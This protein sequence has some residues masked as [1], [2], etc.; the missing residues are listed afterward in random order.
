MRRILLVSLAVVVFASLLFAWG[1]PDPQAGLNFPDP[2]THVQ[3]V[4]RPFS[5]FGW[6][7]DEAA[8]IDYYEIWLIHDENAD[9]VISD[10]EFAAREVI[11][12][13]EDFNLANRTNQRLTTRY[14]VNNQVT[15][16]EKYFLFLYAVGIGGEVTA[17]TDLRGL[18][19]A[20]DATTPDT[21]LAYFTIEG[22]RP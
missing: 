16:A 22:V 15:G 18:G 8:A 10:T 17:D 14:E 9:A 12:R 11:R 20:G 4:A 3:T 2:L 21:S 13:Q 1:P 6:V 7:W 19:P 5:V